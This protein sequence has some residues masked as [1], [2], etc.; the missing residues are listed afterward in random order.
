MLMENEKLTAL[1]EVV[2]TFNLVK[3]E[4]K[5]WKKKET[6]LCLYCFDFFL[7]VVSGCWIC[8]YAH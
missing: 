1:E 5:F 6:I 7:T 3:N 2:G 8:W 4:A